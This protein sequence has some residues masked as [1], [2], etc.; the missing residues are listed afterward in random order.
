MQHQKVCK[1]FLRARLICS[2]SVLICSIV[3]VFSVAPQPS[4]DLAAAAAE[5]LLQKQ[6][7]FPLPWEIFCFEH[8]CDITINMEKGGPNTVFQIHWS[9]VLEAISGSLLVKQ[10]A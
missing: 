7:F 3:G 1:A 4:S 10:K 6:A 8:T 2:I 5:I 9:R